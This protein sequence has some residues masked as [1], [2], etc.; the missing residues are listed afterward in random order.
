MSPMFPSHTHGSL[1]RTSAD[2]TRLEMSLTNLPNRDPRL[3][4]SQTQSPTLAAPSLPSKRSLSCVTAEHSHT[5]C[6]LEKTSPQSG[7]CASS[8]ECQGTANEPK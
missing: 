2:S 1:E 8:V 6:T 5:R 4:A 3:L 7:Q